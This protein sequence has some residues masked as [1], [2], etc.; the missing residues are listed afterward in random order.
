MFEKYSKGVRSRPDI[1]FI[2]FAVTEFC[3][4]GSHATVFLKERAK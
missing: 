3:A 4:L 1:R 2:P